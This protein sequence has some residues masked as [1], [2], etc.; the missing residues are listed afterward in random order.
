MSL[1]KGDVFYNCII[2]ADETWEETL[3]RPGF[4]C[5]QLKGKGLLHTGADNKW[6]VLLSISKDGHLVT[7]EGKGTEKELKQLMKDWPKVER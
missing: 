7:S 3:A 2:P 4:K 1:R 6:T 5:I